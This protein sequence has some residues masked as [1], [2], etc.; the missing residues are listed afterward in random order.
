MLQRFLDSAD[1]E[2]SP[3]EWDA[4]AKLLDLP[5]P[6]TI[7]SRSDDTEIEATIEKHSTDVGPLINSKRLRPSA[8]MRSASLSS[9]RHLMIAPPSSLAAP[10]HAERF[11]LEPV[12]SKSHSPNHDTTDTHTTLEESRKR[13]LARHSL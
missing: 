13:N 3:L 1:S 4:Q 11:Y 6:L 8:S 9:F 7:V 2:T 5:E 12:A 10:T